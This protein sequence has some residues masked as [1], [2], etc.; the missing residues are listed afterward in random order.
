LSEET[1]AFPVSGSCWM[2]IKVESGGDKTRLFSSAERWFQPDP[3]ESTVRSDTS[4]IM[5]IDDFPGR[6]A[7]LVGSGEETELSAGGSPV[8]LLTI[9]FSKLGLGVG[10]GTTVGVG[11]ATFDESLETT[12]LEPLDESL[13]GVGLDS[14][15]ELLDITG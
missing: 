5:G 13:D 14:L 6:S 9:F 2:V 8:I 1:R 3:E 4:E 12:G 7:V 15:E 10:D 11:S